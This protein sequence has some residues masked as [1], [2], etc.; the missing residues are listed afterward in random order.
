MWAPACTAQ[1]VH[2][3]QVSADL[4]NRSL[5]IHWPARLNPNNASAFAHNEIVINAGCAE[6]WA[7]LI[8]AK[9][10]PSWYS[11]SSNVNMVGARN[12]LGA[13]TQFVWTTFGLT[14]HSRVNEFVPDSRVGWF[15]DGAGVSAYHTWILFPEKKGC[16]V[17]TE[18]ASTGEAVVS[19][20]RSNPAYLHE[21]HAI[22]LEELKRYAEGKARS[23][24][25]LKS[26][27]HSQVP[28]RSAST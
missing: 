23:R 28:G 12:E 14:V 13:N 3:D 9:A 6:V 20:S 10:W 7:L 1:T 11:N 21:G 15:A 4:K 22:W 16:R 26:T 5:A 24:V 25:H 27:G 8:D 17:V 2:A 19:A 18:E